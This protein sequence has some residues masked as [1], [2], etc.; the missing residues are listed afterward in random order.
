M[1]RQKGMFGLRI[2][3]IKAATLYGYN[4]R[5]RFR[6]DY[7]DALLSNSLLLDFLKAN[8]LEV[9]KGDTTRDVICLDFSFGTRS[10]EEELEHINS[11]LAEPDLDDAKRSTYSQLLEFAAQ[12]KDAYRKLSKDELRELYYTEGVDVE[13]SDATLH[14]RMLFRNPS[15]AKV[16]QCMFIREELYE[17]TRNWMTMGLG[18]KLPAEKAKIV[19]LSAY[20][21]LVSSSIVG[22]LNIP[23]E[24]VVILKDQSSFCQCAAKIVYAENG[25]CAVRDEETRV[26]NVL[27]DGMALIDTDCC[28]SWANGMVLLRNHFFKAC[29]FKSRIQLFFRDWCAEHG[30]DYE[31]YEI[32][33]IFGRK[34]RLRDIKILTTDNAIKWKKF[35]DLMGD[36]PYEYWCDRVRADGNVWGIVKT[37]HPS[38]LADVQQ[39]SYQ[40]VNT[41]PTTKD[42]VAV[43]AA[44]SIDYVEA[45]K[46]DPVLFD[47]FL[48]RNKND[49]NHYEMMSALYR[50]NPEIADTKWFRHEKSEIL[51]RYVRR[52]KTGKITVEGDN[53]TMC[54]NPYA[55]L[56]Y[57]VG[58]D[59]TQDPTLRPA[60]DRYGGVHVYTKRF[61]DGEFLCAIR[62]PNNSPNNLAYFMN[63]RHHLME[64]YFDF[65]EN[66]IAVNCIGT[67][68]QSR[69]NG[70]DFD[71]DFVFTT[72]NPIMV[73]AGRR[74]YTQ[75]PTIVN[76]LKESGITYGN[77]MADYATMDNKFARSQ[78]AI[79]E[80]S[81]LAQL[82]MSYYWADRE[83]ELYDA[84]VI[85]SVVAQIAIDSIKRLYEVDC[86]DEI[87][88]I[89]KLP[90]MRRE[91]DF[92]EFMKYTRQVPLQKN[93]K[94]RSAEEIRKDKFRLEERINYAIRCPMNYLVSVLG[95]IRRTSN[96]KTRSL[97]DYFVHSEDKGSKRRL[98]LYRKY[99]EECYQYISRLYADGTCTE[100]AFMLACLKYE[101]VIDKMRKTMSRDK[102][103]VNRLIEVAL[104]LDDGD[105]L[106]LAQ[107]N[108]YNQY[109]KTMLRLLFK[110]D[111][112]KFLS[113][114]KKGGS[115]A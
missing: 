114:F 102:K 17:R 10:Y 91:K 62:S 70:A 35:T 1:A 29:A 25:A 64:K 9:W 40:M 71:S 39:M 16:G 115:E 83:K 104:Q 63:V 59:W 5:T 97:R 89:K 98:R 23:V 92:P 79:G 31:T 3:N 58:E 111:P 15:K 76:A 21:P 19:E 55:M 46:N 110:A 90:I 88:R 33:D 105:G 78:L 26:E 87:D 73:E 101:E 100:D 14:Y 6:Y 68:I 84:F 48:Q 74:A 44:N 24:D 37:D 67:D 32:E 65:S 69:L 38:K 18:D 42:E 51:R 103:T 60:P 30:H 95:D 7:T 82:A 108:K 94:A 72:N 85:L 11:K 41:L 61:A 22:R 66:I 93:G 54:G 34:H 99:A 4:A 49:I 50:W 8:G 57:A 43:L 112:E 47:E 75:Y 28:P 81:N 77:T 86:M 27:W 45:I 52:L 96:T 12:R 53:L 2:R 56:M 109:S 20:A 80:S 106:S 36:D 13:Y 107:R 113:N